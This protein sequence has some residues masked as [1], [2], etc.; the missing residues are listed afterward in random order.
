MNGLTK[1]SVLTGAAI[2]ELAQADADNMRL[3]G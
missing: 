1:D 2:K 3:I